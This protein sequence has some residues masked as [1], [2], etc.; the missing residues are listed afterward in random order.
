MFASVLDSNNGANT[1]IGGG[2]GA[3]LGMCYA[4]SIGTATANDDATH[5]MQCI[6]NGASSVAYIDGSSNSVNAGGGTLTGNFGYGNGG[7]I[8]TGNFFEGG[9]WAGAFSGGNQ[10]AM[11]SNQHSYWGF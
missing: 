1:E 11:N 10:S 4:G 9:F 2:N 8:L 5:A 3:S 7:N 6:V